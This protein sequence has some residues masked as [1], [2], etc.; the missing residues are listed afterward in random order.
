MMVL[1]PFI[2][3]QGSTGSLKVS[4]SFGPHSHLD[5]SLPLWLKWP[6]MSAIECA[7]STKGG[8]E[9]RALGL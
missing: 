8:L 2:V 6:F 9:V 7:P 5:C 1:L 4:Q 3:H